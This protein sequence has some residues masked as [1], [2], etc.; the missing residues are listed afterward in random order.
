[1]RFGIEVESRSVSLH[2]LCKNQAFQ[3]ITFRQTQTAQLVDEQLH[4][5]EGNLAIVPNHQR[6]P[7]LLPHKHGIRKPLQGR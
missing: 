4:T 7:N 1:M 6:P 5:S 2:Q 3:L